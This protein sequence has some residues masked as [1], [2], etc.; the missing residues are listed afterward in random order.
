MRDATGSY[1][2]ILYVAGAM[3]VVGGLLLLTLGRYPTSAELAAGAGVAHC[4]QP[5]CQVSRISPPN[6]I[7]SRR[8]PRTSGC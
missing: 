1:D 6:T 3:F 8:T 2:L 7:R 4:T 5:I